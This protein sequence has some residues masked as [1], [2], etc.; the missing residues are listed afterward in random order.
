[1]GHKIIEAIVENG[2]LKHVNEKLPAGRIKVHLIYD[3]AEG[4]ILESEAKK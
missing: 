1:M 4:T 3:V 2:Q